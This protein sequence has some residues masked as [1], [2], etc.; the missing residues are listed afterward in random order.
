MKR[1]ALLA[2]FGVCASFA[3][4]TFALSLEESPGPLPGMRAA[5][6]GATPWNLL[7]KA[8]VLYDE[9]DDAEQVTTIVPPEVEALDGSKV[10]LLGFMFPVEAEL[11]MRRFLLVEY[12]SDCAFCLAAGTEPSRIVEAHSPE[13]LDY[14]DGQVVLSGRLEIVRGD[15]D[16]LVYRLRDARLE[17]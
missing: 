3:P 16:G 7:G 4:P 2:L 5:P 17:D 8:S 6:A 10:K 9:G 14:L 15:A 12:P 11:P 1:F 13:G